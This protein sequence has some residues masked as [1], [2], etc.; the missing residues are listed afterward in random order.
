MSMMNKAAALLCLLAPIFQS[1]TATSGL[2]I[3]QTI[4]L[5]GVKGKFDHFAMDEEGKRLF[6]AASG[7]QSVEVIDLAA[8][9]VVDSLKGFGKPQGL[10]WMASTRTLFVSDGGKGELAIY[11]G[12]PLKRVKTLSLSEDADDMVYDQATG[13]LL[14]AMEDPMQPNLPRL[15]LS[16]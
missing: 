11:A 9:K 16:M 10:A 5:E 4:T 2:K 8:C 15:P 12:S 14:W 3:Q 1:Q 6:A 13:L 7:N